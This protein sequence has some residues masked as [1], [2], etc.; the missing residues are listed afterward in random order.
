[1]RYLGYFSSNLPEFY[2]E[3]L[4][5]LAVLSIASVLAFSPEL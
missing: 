3:S 4:L 1:M 2:L 5:F